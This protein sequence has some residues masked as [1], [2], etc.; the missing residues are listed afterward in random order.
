MTDVADGRHILQSI[1]APCRGNR[2]MRALTPLRLRAW[3]AGRLDVPGGIQMPAEEWQRRH[4]A[5]RAACA[6]PV[7]DKALLS[8]ITPVWNTPVHFL[9]ELAESVARQAERQPLEWVVLDN[10]SDCAELIEFLDRDLSR[11]DHVSFFRSP[12]NLGIVGGTRLC[13]EYAANR[14]ILPLDH[15]DRL[16][17]DAAMVM[18]Q[19]IVTHRYPALLYSD[20]DKLVQGCPAL[21]FFKPDWDPV[22]FVDQCYI[23]HLCAIDR[24][25]ALDLGAYTD[26]TCE[27]SPDWDCFMRFALAGH[28]PVHVPEVVYSWRMHE[29]ST[30]LNMDAKSYIHSSQTA[31]LSRFHDALAQPDHFALD[32][33][34]LFEGTPDWWLR[35]RHVDPAPLALV[36][37]TQASAPSRHSV[38]A[39][40]Y[41][42]VVRAALPPDSSPGRVRDALPERL[43]DDSLVCLIDD[44]LDV[45]DS[46][47]PW[48]ALGIMQSHPDTAV[49]GGRCLDSN[50]LVVEAG[51]Y[52]GFG[53]G[54]DC[55]D[56]GRS[57]N[58]PGY[59][60]WM[61]KRH[62]VSAV[63][64]C[65]A[66]FRAG[67]LRQLLSRGLQP[68]ATLGFL[69]AWAGAL[70]ART[71][72]RVVYSPFLVGQF[73]RTQRL[74]TG[75]GE[76]A[77]FLAA[78]RD[79]IPD[80]RFYPASFGLDL[81]TSF[82]PVPVVKRDAHLRGLLGSVSVSSR[83]QRRP[84]T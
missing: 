2:L 76:R 44:A 9:R 27:G 38:E 66:V 13:L 21:P 78:N 68:E 11:R 69:G 64:S 6:A 29:Q 42:V 39:G 24:L 60:L 19:A 4:A 20:E 5:V 80:T 63:S 51:Q 83:T 32:P 57:L 15:D 33:S 1:A 41:P 49:V 62:S 17:T 70:A 25:R 16:Y 26:A 31:V 22:L 14:Y 28:I 73:S 18:A 54:S 36:S 67:F 52:F 12:S 37:F 50:S 77:A 8:F 46:E 55:P 7:E 61:W 74:S 75:P 10:G 84:P 65:F 71:G 35:R 72:F 23:A 48:E 40:D 47:W 34:P 79:L 53:S 30:A 43:G 81:A 59:S 45:L 56:A 82:R 3:L 58:D